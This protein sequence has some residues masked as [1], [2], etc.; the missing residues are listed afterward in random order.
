M[1]NDT[2]QDLS[3][4]KDKAEYEGMEIWTL[5]FS[6]ASTRCILFTSPKLYE[7]TTIFKIK[8]EL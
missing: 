2:I 4:E 8:K 1:I 3:P 6:K 7:K 5:G